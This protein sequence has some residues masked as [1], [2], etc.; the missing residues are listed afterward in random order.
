MSVL[1]DNKAGTNDDSANIHSPTMLTVN[2]CGLRTSWPD[3]SHHMLSTRPLAAMVVETLT[4]HDQINTKHKINGYRWVACTD[5][6]R[7]VAILLANPISYK[8]I[9]HSVDCIFLTL[10]IRNLSFSLLGGCASP[11]REAGV[12]TDMLWLRFCTITR[13]HPHTKTC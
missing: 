2:V 6:P 3:F 9:I 4:P 10:T 13:F 8:H 5:S 1:N 7:G 11:N 12:L